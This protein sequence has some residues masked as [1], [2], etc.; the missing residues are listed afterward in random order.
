MLLSLIRRSGIPGRNKRTKKK[1]ENKSSSNERIMMARQV[2]RLPG[3]EHSSNK[4]W[5][6]ILTCYG[7]Q[8]INIGTQ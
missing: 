8:Q 3:Y 2:D 4:Y 5:R 6:D 7:E 1:K